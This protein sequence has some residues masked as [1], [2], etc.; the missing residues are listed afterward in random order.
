[1][2]EDTALEN[3]ALKRKW[4]WGNVFFAGF[5]ALVFICVV[6][7]VSSYDSKQELAWV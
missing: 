6:S 7:F 5:L 4:T 1:M 2:S 3:L